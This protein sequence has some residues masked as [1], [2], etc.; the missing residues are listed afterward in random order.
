MPEP[1]D[2]AANSHKSAPVHTNFD[3]IP[4]ASRSH[5]NYYTRQHP[6]NADCSGL[7]PCAHG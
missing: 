5:Y 4:A 3:T 1:Y 7:L 6:D 2:P